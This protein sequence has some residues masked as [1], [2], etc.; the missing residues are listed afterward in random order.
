MGPANEGGMVDWSAALESTGGDSTL[1]QELIE[2]FLDEGPA[3]L[4]AIRSALENRDG[5][6]LRRSAH[7]LKGSLRIFGATRGVELAQEIESRGQQEVWDG[8]AE[9]CRDLE[10]YMTPV[11]AELKTRGNG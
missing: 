3:L 8:T 6:L 9:L 4:Q 10:A 1:L 7:T 11:I 2:V 5:P